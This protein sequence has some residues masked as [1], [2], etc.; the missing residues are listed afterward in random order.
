M[1]C[2]ARDR[3]SVSG[4]V[5]VSWWG[6]LV[7]LPYADNARGPDRFDCWGLVRHVLLRERGIE[8][9]LHDGIETRDM[10]GVSVGMAR[11]AAIGPF[12]AV[13]LP[14]AFDVVLMTESPASREPGHVGV[15]VTGVQLLHI[16]RRTDSCVMR[17]DDYRVA[18]R[19]LGFYRHEA[20]A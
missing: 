13:R 7:G 1:A 9:P 19:V 3:R 6:D 4:A 2:C 20:L 14:Q 5:P 15:M 16:W 11:E 8:L 10:R 12:V 17:L 18:P